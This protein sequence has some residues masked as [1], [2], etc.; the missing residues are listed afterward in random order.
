M[1]LMSSNYNIFGLNPTKE[2]MDNLMKEPFTTE[3]L[4]G[5]FGLGGQFIRCDVK[6]GTSVSKPA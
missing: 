5:Y 6:I 4:V 2:Q 1:S 3:T